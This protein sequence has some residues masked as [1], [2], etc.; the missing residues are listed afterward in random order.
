MIEIGP[1]GDRV[2]VAVRGDLDVDTGRELQ[3]ALRAALARSD[4][5]VDLDLGGVGFCDC[6]TLNVLL[7]LRE[8]AR[9]EAKTVVVRAAGPAAARLLELSGAGYLFAVGGRDAGG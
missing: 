3:Q 7:A 8:R 1:G 6:S 9:H 4:R 5:G 2:R